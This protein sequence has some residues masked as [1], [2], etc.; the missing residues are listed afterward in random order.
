[1]SHVVVSCSQR[2]K[3]LL[4]PTSFIK[5]TCVSSRSKVTFNDCDVRGIAND[6]S[7]VGGRCC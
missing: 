6:G 2:Q 4:V 3:L 7:A 1:M 5:L